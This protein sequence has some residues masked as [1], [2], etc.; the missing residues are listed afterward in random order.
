MTQLASNY[1]PVNLFTE[2][3]KQSRK[4]GANRRNY[5]TPSIILNGDEASRPLLNLGVHNLLDG[6]S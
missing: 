6:I 3:I 5:L 1:D 2:E 4:L